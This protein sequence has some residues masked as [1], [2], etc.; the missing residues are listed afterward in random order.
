MADELGIFSD[1]Q[2]FNFQKKA[3][4]SEIFLHNFYKKVYVVFS[5]IVLTERQF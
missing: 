3:S 5:T 2:N 1:N 4:K